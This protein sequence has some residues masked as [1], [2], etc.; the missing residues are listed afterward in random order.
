MKIDGIFAIIKNSLITVKYIENE[1]DE[2]ERIFDNWTDV[3]FLHD[4][5]T[6]HEKDLSSG[7]Y[8]NINIEQAIERTIQEAEDLEETILEISQ[9][10][11]VDN[12]EKLQTIF[13]PLDNNEYAIKDHQKTKAYGLKKK[14][15]LRI[16]AIRIDANTFVV[17]GG[18]IKLTED[19]NNRNHLKKELSKLDTTKEYLIENSLFDESDF[20]YLESK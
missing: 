13:K 7:F 11:K 2:F 4:F 12:Y 15:W 16:Y 1:T 18:N 5:F 6:K 19:M 17:S 8:G 3:E 10:G 14:S 9:T 20:E